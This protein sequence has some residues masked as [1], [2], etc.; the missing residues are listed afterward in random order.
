MF[1]LNGWFEYLE[2]LIISMTSS[3]IVMVK[4]SYWVLKNERK[5]IKNTIKLKNSL[6][7]I[8]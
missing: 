4:R 7:V 6:N 2:S 1:V 3:E 5:L 8:F